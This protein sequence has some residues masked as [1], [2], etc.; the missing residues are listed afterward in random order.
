MQLTRRG[1]Y[2]NLPLG[3]L[4]ALFLVFIHIPDQTPKSP[5]SLSFLRQLLPLFDLTGFA[6]FAPAVTMFLLGLQF[7]SESYGWGSS[8]VIGLFCGAAATLALFLFWEHRMGDQAM[9]PLELVRQR[10]MW[11]SCLNMGFLM[12]VVIGG[13]SFMPIYFQSVKG[14]SPV[15]SGVHMLGS[16]LSQVFFI[17]LSGALGMTSDPY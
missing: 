3:G 12:T 8:E 15:M 7:G 9:I 13:S 16:I 14:F 4:A 10:V 1:F 17:L 2:I 6:L 5:I 11:T